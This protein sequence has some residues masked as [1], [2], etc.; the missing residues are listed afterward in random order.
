MS[1][2]TKAPWHFWT[3]GI[4]SL[5]WNAM[6]GV[7]Y[8]LTKTENE[9]YLKDYTPEQIAYFLGFPLWGSVFWA[10][11][12]WG[13]IVGSLLLLF[14][15]RFAVHAF[16]ISVLGLVGTTVYSYALSDGY[17]MMG[18]VGVIFSI[19]LWVISLFL[20]FYAR[21]ANRKGYLR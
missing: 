20:V 3:I 11:G 17:G 2:N 21:H 18:M 19:V 13:A 6:G 5:L 1:E 9:A 4:V 10:L 12:V 8:V 15:S 7:D 14:R 16:A